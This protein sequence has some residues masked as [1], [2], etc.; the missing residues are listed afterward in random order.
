M[1]LRRALVITAVSALALGLAACEGGA[2]EPSP[3]STAATT[4]ASPTEP[5]TASAT[6]SQPAVAAPDP[7]AYPGMDEQTEEGAMQAY[8]FFWDTLIYGYQTGDSTPFRGLSSA[9]CS[10]CIDAARD[11]DGFRDRDEYWGPVELSEHFLNAQSEAE[12]QFVVSYGFSLSE[13][14]EPSN[15]AG[16]RTSDPET[17]YGAAGRLKWDGSHWVVQAVDLET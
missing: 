11:I 10:Y 13:H 9:D 12:D 5:T 4:T 14:D 16:E 7:S 3:S 6:T 15:V 8:K 17:A 1:T 2:D